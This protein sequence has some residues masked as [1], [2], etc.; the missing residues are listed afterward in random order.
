MR[1]VLAAAALVALAPACSPPPPLGP[2]EPPTTAWISS[3]RTHLRDETGR[4]VLLR[5]VNVRARAIFDVSLDPARCPPPTDQLEE[6]PE[7]TDADLDRMRT[8]G[9]SVLRLPIHWSAIEPTEG[10]YDEA[11]L[12]GVAAL[13][14][15]A[16][17]RE[18]YVVLDFHEDA[19]GPD[20]GE[21]GA[22]LWATHPAP[23]PSELLCGPLADTL[24]ARRTSRVVLDAFAGFFD[25]TTGEPRGAELRVAFAAM[26]A[27]VAERFSGDPYVLGYDLFN[28]PLADDRALDRFH[29][30]VTTAIRAVD[31]RHLL[32]FEPAAYRN[33]T[34]RGPRAAAPFADPGGLYAV[35]LYTLSFADPRMELDTVTRERLEPNV[36]RALAEAAGYEVPMFVG[37]WGIRPDSPGSAAYVRFMYELFDEHFTSSTVW[38]WREQSQGSWGFYDWDETTGEWS[39]RESVFGAH[40]RVVAQRVAGEPT[41]MAYDASARRLELRFEGRSD[42]APHVI[43]VPAAVSAAGALAAR[44]DGALVDPPPVR[45]ATTGRLEVLCAGAGPHTLTLEAAP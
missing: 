9:F 15:R 17:E 11:Y 35:H 28:E 22:P 40:T 3:D 29:E 7:L 30:S 27:H 2:Y 20:V 36:T 33:L 8:I 32:L 34:E 39:E 16:A 4:A 41:S 24:D 38:L 31:A 18:L 19:W 13:V 1:R 44:C 10:V 12:D 42:R 25:D 26:T 6:I 45:D 43:F 14:A 37:E 21:D 5:G 23:D